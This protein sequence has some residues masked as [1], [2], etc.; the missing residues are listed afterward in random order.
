MSTYPKIN[1]FNIPKV[2]ENVENLRYLWI[3]APQSV[4]ADGQSK[5]GGASV[6][7]KREME[8]RLPLKLKNIT[9]SGTGFTKLADNI[10]RVGIKWFKSRKT[11]QILFFCF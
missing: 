1:N 2:L 9:I 8:G 6:D 11:R 4:S 7:L 10:F 5:G 3:E